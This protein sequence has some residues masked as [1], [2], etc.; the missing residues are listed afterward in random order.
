M[1]NFD[2]LQVSVTVII[3][4]PYFFVKAAVVVVI[5]VMTLVTM[6][7]MVVVTV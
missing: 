2:L 5:T 6:T 7:V 4:T 1:T 3:C